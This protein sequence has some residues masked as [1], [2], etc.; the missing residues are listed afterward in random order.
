M[1]LVVSKNTEEIGGKVFNE[2][3]KKGLFLYKWLREI[4]CLSQEG[5]LKQS[6]FFSGKP[7]F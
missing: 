4:L 5:E 2:N 7:L 3:K 1:A 6:L